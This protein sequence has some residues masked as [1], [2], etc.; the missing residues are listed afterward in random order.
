MNLPYEDKT[1]TVTIFPFALISVL[2]AV[3][4]LF[5]YKIM[6]SA[7]GVDLITFALWLS[8][9]AVC[10]FLL[11]KFVYL[12][13]RVERKNLVV[14]WGIFGQSIPVSEIYRIK[15]KSVGLVEFFA[16][17]LAMV[18]SRNP[19]EFVNRRG[20]GIELKVKGGKSYFISTDRPEELVSIIQKARAL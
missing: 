13:V 17:V 11:T 10:L 20:M 9:S 6:F 16:S 7:R 19:K 5:I 14:S 4:G 2:S 15:I 8:V 12:N 18:S 1:S 3:S